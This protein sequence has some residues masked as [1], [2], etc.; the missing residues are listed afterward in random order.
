MIKFFEGKFGRIFIVRLP[1]DGDLLK[2]IEE[3][4]EKVGVK[5]GVLWVVGAVKKA[6]VKYYSQEEK[7]YLKISLDLPLE[8]LSCTGN[9]SRFKGK[10]IAHIHLVFG[11]KEGK[12]FGGHLDEGTIIFSA[13]MFLLEVKDVVLEREYDK[14]TGLNLFK[15]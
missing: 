9:I 14:V 13:E 15:V 5:A 4:A 6:V 3:F 10:T 2:S 8:I 11:D 12:T 1:T 7:K